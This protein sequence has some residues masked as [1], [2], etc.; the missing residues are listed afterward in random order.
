VMWTI[1]NS[2]LEVNT[3]LLERAQCPAIRP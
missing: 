3:S 2:W 1:K